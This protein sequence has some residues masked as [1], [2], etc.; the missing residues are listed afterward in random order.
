LEFFDGHGGEE[1]AVYCAANLHKFLLDCDGYLDGKIEKSLKDAFMN[2]DQAV[3]TDE[4]IKELQ[5]IAGINDGNPEDEAEELNAL[6]EEA[7]MPLQDIVANIKANVKEQLA[8]N[9]YLKEES[10]DSE[11]EE[12]ESTKDQK[13]EINGK[14]DGESSKKSRKQKQPNK[15]IE[16]N[17]EEGGGSSSS[18]AGGSG[19]GGS[20]SGSGGSGSSSKDLNECGG[21]SSSGS[22]RKAYIPPAVVDDDDDDEDEDDPDFDSQE[23]NEEEGSDSEEGSDDESGSEDE[24]DQFQDSADYDFNAM[25]EEVGKD[26]G[27]TAVVALVH[28]NKLYVANAGD[29]RCILCRSGKVVEM[30]KDHSPDVED[31]RNRIEAAGSK[32]CSE[33]RINGGINLTRAI[34]DH[35]YK[36]NK[37]LPAEKQ[38]VIALPDVRVT[39]LTEEDE[40][41]VL[42]CDG[43][44]NAMTN[45]EVL[46]FVRERLN[47]EEKI[48]KICEEIFD[49]C[50]APDTNN[51][52][53]GCDNMT[54]LIIRFKNKDAQQQ[55]QNGHSNKREHS[56]DEQGSKQKSKKAKLT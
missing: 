22:P 20:G 21:S 38:A 4:V 55:Q 12:K 15:R 45:D 49:H 5:E 11:S 17:G 52:G 9:G 28:N 30:S 2:I 56:S 6:L 53:T 3:T 34:G 27:T 18:G 1:V 32:I 36:Q 37:D 43:I 16:S 26:S 44:W 33:G 24:D 40:F 54:C 46:D 8:E 10:E 35:G 25:K 48:S 31:E 23:E 19:S 50:L 14:A 47:R 7:N 13:E 51:D 39:D 42:A 29:S 41:L